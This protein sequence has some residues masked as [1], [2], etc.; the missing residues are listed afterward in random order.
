MIETVG[1]ILRDA[2]FTIRSY[3]KHLSFFGMAVSSLALGIGANIVVFTLFYTVLL[4]P[5]PYP[6]ADRLLYVEET[7]PAWQIERMG[8]S[9]PDLVDFQERNRTF[10]H[11][12]GFQYG[13]HALTGGSEPERIMGCEVSTDFLSALGVQPLLGRGFR[14]EEEGEGAEPV[15]LIGA[16]LWRG[17]FAGDRGVIGQTL[18]LDGEPATIVGVL[19]SSFRFPDASDV[20]VPFRLSRTEYRGRNSIGVI[21]RLRPGTGVE[22]AE[23]DMVR[24][25]RELGAVHWGSADALGARVV[26]LRSW[27]LG[28]WRA[29]AVAFYVV[30]CLV[31]LLACANV[32]NLLMARNTT[33]QREIAVRTS[34]G[35]ARSRIVRQLLTEGITLSFL[36]GALG[37]ILGLYGR[38]LLIGLSPVALPSY[39]SFAVRP[40]P[41]LIIAGIIVAS[42]VIFSLGPAFG[43]AR[44]DVGSTLRAESSRISS[45]L[46]KQRFR[47][48][49]VALQLAMALAV[50]IGGG[51]MFKSLL[52]QMN[53]D[54]GFE[55][56]GVV[57]LQLSLPEVRYLEAGMLQG[58]YQRVLEDAK[59]LPGIS[60]ASIVTDLPVGRTPRDGNFY[61]EG[62]EL[63]SDKGPIYPFSY[64]SAGY[65]GTMGIPLLRG[66]D[67][68]DA[69]GTEG[70]P[71]VIIISEL[72]ARR[73]WPDQDPVGK[74]IA[75]GDGPP[76]EEEGWATVVGVVG[77][78]FTDGYGQP[79]RPAVYEPLEKDRAFNFFLVARTTLAPR[80]AFEQ[81]RGTI[82]AID[83]NVPIS[84]SRTMERA[85]LEANWQLRFYT[86]LFAAFSFIAILLASA[87]VYGVMSFAVASRS[88]EFA[89]R[90]AFGAQRVQVERLVLRRAMA[91]SAVGL[92]LG[93]SAA[94]G[95]ARLLT[96]M[97]FQVGSTDLQVF[98]LSTLAMA[99][100]A[101]LS[102]Y[103]PARRVLRIEPMA[104]LGEE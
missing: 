55:P 67:F 37:V 62:V 9:Y 45:G 93:L 24:I 29:A 95:G 99:A 58:F 21:G 94:L 69:D 53:V 90:M 40:A 76:S 101:L 11:L 70:S 75:R 102:G 68:T 66:R 41:A 89:L 1:S 72:F 30:A 43:A 36:G 100:V 47:S 10:S 64:A 63:G 31:L 85:M 12:A 34:L 104:V 8:F 73:H 52:K 48:A 22:A 44:T 80:A 27:L 33:R 103:L 26:P 32:A 83:P 91:L 79:A 60:D 88:K 25:A 17:R 38:D 13:P 7:A 46:G 28:D 2:R 16:G 49:L 6:S 81:L 51:L 96:G 59:A 50:L 5:L 57:S 74:R 61:P 23:A 97:L 18:T 19:P 54:P 42:G 71:S 78:T 77:N 65:F 14:P 20:W 15:V 86:W 56:S 98:G 3:R 4:E 87:G 82:H 39:L 35:A 92:I 84:A